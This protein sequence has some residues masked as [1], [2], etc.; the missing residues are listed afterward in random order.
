MWKTFIYLLL[1][2]NRMVTESSA[3]PVGVIHNVFVHRSDLNST[4]VNGNW[5]E[6]LCQMI[7]GHAFSS[8]NCFTDTNTCQMYAKTNQSESFSISSQPNSSFYF[9][10]LPLAHE[11][12]TG[13]LFGSTTGK[14]DRWHFFSFS[15]IS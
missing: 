14:C 13:V 7:F 8:F 9:L 5:Q 11:L 6:C 1:I 4:L 12:S 2:Y 15:Q 10:S 3:T